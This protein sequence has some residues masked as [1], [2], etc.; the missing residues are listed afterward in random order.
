MS[1]DVVRCCQ[2]LSDVV[3]C[4]QMSSDV[5]RCRQM[6]SDVV[7]CRQMSSDAV[8]CCQMLSVA[9]GFH[10]ASA[11]SSFHRASVGSSRI[12]SGIHRQLQDSIG[13]PSEH[14]V[15]SN[16]ER[17][18]PRFS[19]HATL[20]YPRSPVRYCRPIQDSIGYP[21]GIRRQLQDSIGYPS[22]PRVSTGAFR[23]AITYR[24]CGHEMLLEAPYRS[25]S[26][27]LP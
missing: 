3:R 15:N 27:H 2:M 22:A 11:D 13:Y 12:P 14:F 9:R 1:S 18:T 26:R 7:R 16:R 8:R 5:V 17:F 4:R 23:S 24:D 25:I 6:S 20:L 10:R 19:I 21:S